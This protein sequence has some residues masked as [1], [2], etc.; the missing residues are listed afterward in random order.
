V[1][2]P[3]WGESLRMLAEDIGAAAGEKSAVELGTKLVSMA[4]EVDPI[5][6]GDLSHWCGPAVW[7]EVRKEMGARLRACYDLPDPHHKECALAA[8]LA[9]GSDD[10][11]DIVVPLL[12]DPNNQ[13]RAAVYHSGAELLP[14]SLGPRWD[15]VVRGWPEEAR[16]D[17]ILQLSNDPWLAETVEQLAL[18][19]PS[20]R[21]KWN[22]ARHLSWYGFTQK[23]EKLLGPLDDADFRTAV[24]SLNPDEIPPSLRQRAIELTEATYKETGDAFERLKILHLLKNLGAKQIAERMKAELDALDEKQLQAGNEGG[25]KWALEEL[26]KS[27]PQW[28]SDW[29]GKKC[30]PE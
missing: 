27:D 22:A 5:F 2:E 13:K 17:F 28:V 29:L 12:S 30:W 24:R 7:N 14:S 9:T 19:D 6:A 4:L 11:K 21:I 15:E 10:F 18:A 20:P 25:T 23:V 1:N 8:M 26:Q 3:R 16:L